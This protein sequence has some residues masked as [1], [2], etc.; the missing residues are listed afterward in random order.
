ME[1]NNVEKDIEKIIKENEE[2]QKLKDQK[3]IG[4]KNK[5]FCG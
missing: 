3:E 5:L 4:T 2:R 1:N